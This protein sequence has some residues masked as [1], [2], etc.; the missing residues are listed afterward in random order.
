MSN[1]YDANKKDEFESNLIK[2][3]IMKIE[4]YIRIIS[5]SEK[6]YISFDGVAPVAKL[7]QQR[8]RRHKSLLE[9][10]LN[11]QLNPKYVESWD[12]ISITPGTNF[13]C[14]LNKSVCD[15]FTSANANAN[16]NSNSNSNANANT[17]STSY[18]IVSGS[19]EVGEGE[20]KIFKYMRDNRLKLK[21][22]LYKRSC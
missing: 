11:K 1:E 18:Y 7:E 17:N 19:N 3:T 10:K 6:V 14:L 13:M 15:H 12:K 2:N 9:V 22:K 4:E 16:S 5:P 21:N 20:H 8:T